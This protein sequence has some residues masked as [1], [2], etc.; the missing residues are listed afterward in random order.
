VLS[1]YG[2][3]DDD[4]VGNFW[5]EKIADRAV[6]S[7]RKELRKIFKESGKVIAV[8]SAHQHWNR[9]FLYDGI[10]YITITSLVENFNNDGIAAEAYTVVEL[11]ADKLIIDV[12]GNDPAHYEYPAA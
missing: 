11:K 6:I 5:F 8:I 10:P 7:N 1:H 3:A 4:M 9:E 2:L 12:R